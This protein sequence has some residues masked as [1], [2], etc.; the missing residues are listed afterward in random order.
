MTKLMGM[1]NGHDDQITIS[2]NCK[3]RCTLPDFHLVLFVF[4]CHVHTVQ[5]NLLVA[6]SGGRLNNTGPSGG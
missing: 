6:V 3:L 5:G 2:S 4:H 1:C